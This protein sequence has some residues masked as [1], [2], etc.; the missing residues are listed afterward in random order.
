MVGVVYSSVEGG[1]CC[2]R[3]DM[4]AIIKSEEKERHGSS[5]HIAN[6]CESPGGNQ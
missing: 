1:G 3:C 2:R 5:C 4:V 6:S